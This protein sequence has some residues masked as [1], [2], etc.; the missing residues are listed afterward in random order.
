MNSWLLILTVTLAYVVIVVTPGPN[1]LITVKTSVSFSRHIGFYTAL[2][3]TSGTFIHVVAGFVGLTTIIWQMTWLVSFAKIMGASYL[4]Y[5]GYKAL[6]SKASHLDVNYQKELR[7][8]KKSKAFRVG[9]YTCL[10]NPKSALFYLSLFTAI[11]P[12]TSPLWAQVVMIFIMVILSASWYTS[13]AFLFSQ[14]IV[15]NGY[16]KI[17]RFINYLVGGLFISLGLR[18]T[19]V[20]E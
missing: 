8:F 3:I 14:A 11:I 16:V 7:Y 19:F 6:T 17:E 1:F 9:F 10:S 13:V 4:I 12:A 18:L 15:Q 2:G 5:L 20:R